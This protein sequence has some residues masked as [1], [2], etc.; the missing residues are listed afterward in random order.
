MAL[1]SSFI[2]IRLLFYHLSKFFIA[3][4]REKSSIL[5]LSGEQ[6]MA[7]QSFFFFGQTQ[8]TQEN[9]ERSWKIKRHDEKWIQEERG[10][11]KYYHTVLEAYRSISL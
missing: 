8:K 5:H 7:K 10:S 9:W 3:L 2:I 11:P 4:S 1:Y 6:I